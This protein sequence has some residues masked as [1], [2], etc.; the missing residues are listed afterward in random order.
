[1]P[2][3]S[4]LPSGFGSFSLAD[5]NAFRE[6]YSGASPYGSPQMTWT[7]LP[8]VQ[9]AQALSVNPNVG[10][11][12]GAPEY[13]E[14][15]ALQ[16]LV[17]AYCYFPD[18]NFNGTLNSDT[19]FVSFGPDNADLNELITFD[20][21]FANTTAS[22]TSV[23]IRE[24]PEAA[25]AKHSGLLVYGVKGLVSDATADVRSCIIDAAWIPSTL[26]SSGNEEVN[27]VLTRNYSQPLPA[28]ELLSISSDWTTN[29]T[30]A[31]AEV[32]QSTD[33]FN[34]WPD[35]VLAVGLSYATP[36][37]SI[38]EWSLIEANATIGVLHGISKQQ[39]AA[40]KNH[41]DSMDLWSK[42]A[43]IFVATSTQWTDAKDLTH[44]EVT[45]L[46][47]GYGYD[48]S[49]TTVIL[50]ITVVGLYCLIVT[51]YLVYSIGSGCTGSSW[52]SI[53]ELLMLGLCSNRPGHLGSISAGVGTITTFREPVSIKA[54]QNTSLELMFDNDP[55][56]QKSRYSDVEANK[57]Y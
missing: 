47:Q 39:R 10:N 11:R 1:M 31:V 12:I 50:A 54:G 6:V 49:Q 51:A 8:S 32:Y 24:M 26:N 55:R 30:N 13:V 9:I 33:I 46:R 35:K 41:I 21:V 48:V 38:F 14:T 45:G 29:L 52:D 57:R 4:E 43:G 22:N 25:K 28:S 40:L 56:V 27:F 15:Q 53:S 17:Q 19:S 18:G 36:H 3:I 23:Y 34:M 5:P 7:T 37:Q 16:P 44:Q 42:Y 2:Q 20:Q